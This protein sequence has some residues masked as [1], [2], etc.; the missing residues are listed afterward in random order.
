MISVED[1]E[2][3]ADDGTLMEDGISADDDF[4]FVDS[5]EDLSEDLTSFEDVTEDATEDTVNEFTTE[6]FRRRRIYGGVDDERDEIR[7]FCPIRVHPTP[8]LPNLYSP[9]ECARSCTD[10]ENPRICY[11]HFDVEYYSTQ[12]K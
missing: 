1:A 6:T 4:S 10:D 3:P 11:Y 9:L 5:F 8:D 2:T 7:G 12:N